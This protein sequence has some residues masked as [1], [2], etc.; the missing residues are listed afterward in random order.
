MTEK[1]R[2]RAREREREQGHAECSRAFL[3]G[4]QTPARSNAAA[5]RPSERQRA[6]PRAHNTPLR[7]TTTTTTPTAQSH[8]YSAQPSSAWPSQQRTYPGPALRLWQEVTYCA[9]RTRHSSF[10][11]RYESLSSLLPRRN[12]GKTSPI[13]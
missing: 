6:L 9:A 4:Y 12:L 3:E 8:C 13:F 11:V 2:E 1:E 7:S 5:L 10:S